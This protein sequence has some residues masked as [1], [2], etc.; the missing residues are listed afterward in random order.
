MSKVLTVYINGTDEDASLEGFA[1]SL[2]NVLHALS[3]QN[4][5]QRSICL[6]GCAIGNYDPRDL[7]AIFTFHL[8]KQLDAL[9]PQIKEKLSTDEKLILN[10]Y[11]FSRGGAAAF[12]LCQKLKHIPAEQLEINVCAL[13]P[14]PGN[15]IRAAYADTVTGAQTTLSSRIADLSDCPNVKNMLVL[16]TNQPLPDMTCHGPLLP[17]KPKNATMTVDVLAGCHKSVERLYTQEVQGKRQVDLGR[18]GRVTFA[19][20]REFLQTCGTR[21]IE[22]PEVIIDSTKLTKEKLLKTMKQ[23]LQSVTHT[24]RAMH[25]YN[26]IDTAMCAP[27]LNLFHQKLAGVPLDPSRCALTVKD[28]NPQA[29]YAT[30]QKSLIPVVFS[31]S[32]AVLG[33]AAVVYAAMR[34]PAEDDILGSSASFGFKQ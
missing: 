9:L 2:A 25:Y 21:F 29:S 7:G 10:L 28:P 14:V 22:N 3:E 1:T 18:A 24:T 8:E 4:N 27:Y 31:R 13:E 15:F 6:D 11:G 32:F 23:Q 5:N 33:A 20:V 17:I 19:Y 30:G 12:W 26:Q 16:F 34:K